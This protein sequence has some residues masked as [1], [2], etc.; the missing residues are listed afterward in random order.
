[1]K[2]LD[3]LIR[4]FL[5]HEQDSNIQLVIAGNSENSYGAYLKEIAGKDKRIIFI[6]P[7]YGIDKAALLTNC[8]AYC[9]VSKS[10]G[11]PI[12]LLEAMSYGKP[13]LCS[14]IPANKEALTT[15]LGLWS[16]VNDE[17]SLFKTMKLV[18][19]DPR[20]YKEIGMKLKQRIFDN[21]TWDKVALEYVDYLHSIGIK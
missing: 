12:A 4:A 15:S 10:E 20:K 3:I 2:N 21:L 18:E 14:E 8:M 6:G 11:F 13:C 17:F 5:L 9:L 16:N 7:V 1:M 19:S